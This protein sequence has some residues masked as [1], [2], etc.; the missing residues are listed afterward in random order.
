MRAP[1]LLMRQEGQE[2]RELLGFEL[3]LGREH[4]APCLAHRRCVV[5]VYG[6]DVCST[7]R[8]LLGEQRCVKKEAQ[9]EMGRRSFCRGVGLTRMCCKIGGGKWGGVLS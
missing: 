3:L 7:H 9:P 8:W 4:A 5:T 2:S 6:V 1:V